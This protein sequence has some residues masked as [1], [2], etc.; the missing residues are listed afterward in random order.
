MNAVSAYQPVQISAARALAHA[1]LT[2]QSTP[3]KLQ[4]LVRADFAKTIIK[5]VYG[6]DVEDSE[7]DKSAYIDVPERVLQNLNTAGTPGRFLV[8]SF[9]VCRST[10]WSGCCSLI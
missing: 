9:P 6:I 4:A 10:A 3:D 5:I 8:D 2:A 1:L 7:S